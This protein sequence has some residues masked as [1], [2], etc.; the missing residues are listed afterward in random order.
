[1]HVEV[2]L[3][4]DD[5]DRWTRTRTALPLDELIRSADRNFKAGGWLFLKIRL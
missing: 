3:S 1:L 2:A 4:G 5:V